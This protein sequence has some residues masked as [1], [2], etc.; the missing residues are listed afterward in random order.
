MPIDWSK[1]ES[2]LQR[3]ERLAD[4]LVTDAA[5]MILVECE[6]NPD[7]IM[8]RDFIKEVREKHNEIVW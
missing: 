7:Y 5:R 3:Q 8:I 2:P 6:K 4:E 1:V